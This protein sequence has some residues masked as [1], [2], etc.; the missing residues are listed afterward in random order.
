M[1]NKYKLGVCVTSY[2][3]PDKAI[4]LLGNLATDL[5]KYIDT[6]V[7]KL[8]LYVDGGSK[9]SLDIYKKFEPTLAN[10]GVDVTINEENN[11]AF[12]AKY[13][14]IKNASD[15]CDWIIHCDDDDYLNI[16]TMHELIKIIQGFN[17]LSNT[18]I[19]FD[20]L[21]FG[22]KFKGHTTRFEI[23]KSKGVNALCLNGLLF[24]SFAVKPNF[25]LYE[26]SYLFT[27]TEKRDVWGDDVLLASF[28]SKGIKDEHIGFSSK[29]LSIQYYIDGEDHLCTDPEVLKRT[30][31][32]KKEF[33]RDVKFPKDFIK[34]LTHERNIS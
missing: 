21:R 23:Q 18:I 34:Q 27:L 10:I 26:D 11:G 20:C 17:Q 4:R 28:L 9:E 29:I 8:F 2:Q 25:E 31:K 30:S 32:E 6:K 22:D 19:Q 5:K 12:R 7:L 13:F 15:K 16:N 3:R 1:G 14:N 33:V 24:N